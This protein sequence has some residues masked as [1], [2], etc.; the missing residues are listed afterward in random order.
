MVFHSYSL[1][2]DP[3]SVISTF[4]TKSR[5]KWRK[6]I[7]KVLSCVFVLNIQMYLVN[8]H[9]YRYSQFLFFSLNI[10]MSLLFVPYLFHRTHNPLWN[11]L[12]SVLHYKYVNATY[13]D[14]DG[15]DRHPVYDSFDFFHL[16]QY[17]YSY[18]LLY[19]CNIFLYSIFPWIKKGY[20]PL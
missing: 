4:E 20:D 19:E 9:L 2:I 7:G 14:E 18:L 11:S 5:L 15:C 13:M 1:H 3:V 16:D 10:W 12:Y 6:Y 17:I 8:K